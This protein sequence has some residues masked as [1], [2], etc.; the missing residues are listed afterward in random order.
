MWSFIH[1]D[2]YGVP[3]FLKKIEIEEKPN[4]IET[5]QNNVILLADTSNELKILY[6]KA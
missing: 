4:W 1:R 5:L 2:K 3:N 6:I